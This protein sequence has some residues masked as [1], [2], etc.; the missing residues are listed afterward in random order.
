MPIVGNGKKSQQIVCLSVW[1]DAD[2]ETT[3]ESVLVKFMY[4][5]VCS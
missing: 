5:C 3:G 4:P 1:S 2:M